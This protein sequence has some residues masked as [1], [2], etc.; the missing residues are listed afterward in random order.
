M[1]RWIGKACC[2][3][4]AA[5]S[6]RDRRREESL[7]S[8]RVSRCS[9]STRWSKGRKN[10]AFDGGLAAQEVFE[11]NGIEVLNVGGPW[12]SMLALRMPERTGRTEMCRRTYPNTSIPRSAFRL[13]G[14]I[15]EPL[16]L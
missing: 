11:R 10:D 8:K 14:Q 13:S 12:E 1:A 16:I 5:P 9:I 7:G 15:I 4:P 6:G 2:N 3:V